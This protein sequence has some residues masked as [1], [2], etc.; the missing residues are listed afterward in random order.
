MQMKTTV[1][2]RMKDV[3]IKYHQ[4]ESPAGEQSEAS[5]TAGWNVNWYKPLAKRYGRSYEVKHTLALRPSN[6][7]PCIFTYLH[8]QEKWKYTCVIPCTRVFVAD[9]LTRIKTYRQ[10][11]YS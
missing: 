11:K 3:K 4:T 10:L 9:L 1:N 5:H 6:C 8:R 7:T 2:V